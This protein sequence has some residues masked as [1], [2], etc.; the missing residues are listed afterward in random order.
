MEKTKNI[1]NNILFDFAYVHL[2]PHLQIGLH[3]HAAWELS[4]IIRG[5]GSRL[6]GE[7]TSPFT[8]GDLVL[9]P[10]GMPHCWYFGTEC[11]D[12]RG[13]IINITLTFTSELLDG[14]TKLFP[15]MKQVKDNILSRKD[16]VTFSKEHTKIVAGK[17]MAMND[18]DELRRL[19]ILLD[20]FINLAGSDALSVGKYDKPDKVVERMKMIKLYVSCNYNRDIT[21]AD[22][23]SYVG[24]S[25]ASFCTF[26]KKQAGIGFVDYINQIR[27]EKAIELLKDKKHS[28]TEI[29]YS[30]GFSSA[31]YFNRVF[32]KITGEAPSL[33]VPVYE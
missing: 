30:V 32:K 25:R 18:T 1:S 28:I 23:A 27:I 17:L 7:T 11:T 10:P 22:V 5:E 19:P 16:A 4:Y 13:R 20:L 31:S 9:V 14:L 3:E 26:F 6:I 15:S 24:M 2:L 21:L 8:S 29:S 33:Y 12:R